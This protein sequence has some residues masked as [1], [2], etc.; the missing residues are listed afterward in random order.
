MSL[1]SNMQE[2]DEDG[3]T[4]F[5]SVDWSDK[6]L[7]PI[8]AQSA[9]AV[10]DYMQSQAG[11]QTLPDRID[12]FQDDA[13]KILDNALAPEKIKSLSDAYDTYSD[14]KKE[15][16]S[17]LE[18]AKGL[19]DIHV[20]SVIK[21]TKRNL[22]Q[23]SS[24]QKLGSALSFVGRSWEGISIFWNELVEKKPILQILDSTIV[25]PMAISLYAAILPELAVVKS[26]EFV[27]RSIGAVSQGKG[28][29]GIANVATNMLKSTSNHF[30]RVFG[31]GSNK[32]LVAKVDG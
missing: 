10:V 9:S 28:W 25:K 32:E 7:P 15:S 16:A 11:L 6:A 29:K 2:I 19:F 23:G 24:L 26:C 4:F 30:Q 8:V 14:A 12:Q 5:D 1:Q 3:D 31:V 27:G 22:M 20:G 17:L 18:D 13:H 21:K